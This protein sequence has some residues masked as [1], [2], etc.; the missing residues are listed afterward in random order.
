M[1]DFENGPDDLEPF[2][3]PCTALIV[4]TKYCKN[5]LTSFD[6]FGEIC[7]LHLFYFFVEEFLYDLVLPFAKVI[8]LIV[9]GDF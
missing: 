4:M 8:P 2:H 6:N 5:G 7:R 9:E 3:S 1:F